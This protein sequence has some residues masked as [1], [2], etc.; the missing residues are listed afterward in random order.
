MSNDTFTWSFK[1]YDELSKEELH[2]IMKERIEVFIVEQNCVYQDLDHKDALSYHLTIFNEGRFV[3]YARVIPEGISYEGYTSIGR[4]I[5]VFSERK[6]GAGRF[7]MKKAIEFCKELEPELPIKISAQKY[8]LNF[9]Q[10]LGFSPIGEEYLED[11][12][13]HICMVHP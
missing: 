10:S 8:L 3:A 11:N 1:H 12:I 7:L 2:Q 5:S 9:Y 4:V 13:P 6:T